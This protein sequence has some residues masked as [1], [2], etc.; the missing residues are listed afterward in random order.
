MID[1]RVVSD[2]ALLRHAL[3]RAQGLPPAEVISWLRW[4]VSL[5]RGLP[6]Q[7]AVYRWPDPEGLTSE[8]VMLSTS[9][10]ATLAQAYLEVSDLPGVMWATGQGL[11][12]LPGDEELIALRMRARGRQGDLAALRQEWDSYERVLADEWAGGRPS[13]MLQNLRRELLEDRSR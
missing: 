4:P 12:V 3:Q 6:F 7:G 5:L 11:R 9:A 1:D 2:A 8:L 10:S 13:L